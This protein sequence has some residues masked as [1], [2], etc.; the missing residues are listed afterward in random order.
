MTKNIYKINYIQFGGDCTKNILSNDPVIYTIDNVL[1]PDECK[2]IINVASNNMTRAIVTASVNITND[3]TNDVNWL[4]KNHDNII[5]N[6]TKKIANIVYDD[7]Y[8]NNINKNDF[9]DYSEK[10]QVIRYYENQQYKPHYDGWEK[11]NGNLKR[12]SGK[13]GQRLITVLVYLS[14][15]T[16]G[17]KTEF[18][19]LNLK[20]TPQKGR[21]VVFYNC[22]HKT[23]TLN[24]KTLHAGL[25]IIKGSKWAFNLWFRENKVYY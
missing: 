19:R 14:D 11:G 13:Y 25:P 16:E 5:L 22:N 4:S 18:T 7:T 9:I 10:L 23:N 24:E 3:R 12:Y 8:L 17:G 1:T 6:I 20:V 2:H 21:I 15:V